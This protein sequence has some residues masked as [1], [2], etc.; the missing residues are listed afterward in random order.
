MTDEQ[1]EKIKRVAHWVTFAIICLGFAVIMTGA[2][3]IL[4]QFF[5]ITFCR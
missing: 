2:A 4:R 3:W 1:F 5:A